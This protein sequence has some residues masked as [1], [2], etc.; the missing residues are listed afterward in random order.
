M[1]S[2]TVLN[3]A[4][5]SFFFPR[6]GYSCSSFAVRIFQCSSCHIKYFRKDVLEILSPTIKPFGLFWNIVAS[7][8]EG[9]R[10]N[11]ESLNRNLFYEKVIS[12]TRWCLTFVR[13]IYPCLHSFTFIYVYVC[14]YL[15]PIPIEP[16]NKSNRDDGGQ[17]P[18]SCL[19]S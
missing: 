19:Q 17:S 13:A 6:A 8:S 4:N 12:P 11:L 14:V 18:L 10:Q 2:V 9:S 16:E 5:C 3:I 7:F 15:C 1:S